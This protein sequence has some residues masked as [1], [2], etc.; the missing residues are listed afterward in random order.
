VKEKVGLAKK[1]EDKIIL[2]GEEP[3]RNYLSDPPPGYRVPSV[4]NPAH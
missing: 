1:D 2:S 4:S 3:P